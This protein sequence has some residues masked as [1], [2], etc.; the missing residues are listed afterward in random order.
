M[1][2][3]RHLRRNADEHTQWCARDHRCNLGEHRSPEIFTDLPG[4]GRLLITR[5]R[6]GDREYAEIR[7]RI[8][9]HSTEAGARWQISTALGRLR[10]LLAAV[11][12]RPGVTRAPADSIGGTRRPAPL[13]A[14]G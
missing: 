9:L 12:V 8:A 13:R 6:A 5:V 1:R 2:T 10:D 7:G 14:A 11:R 3:T 4:A